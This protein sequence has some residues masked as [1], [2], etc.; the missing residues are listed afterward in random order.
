MIIINSRFLTQKTTGVQ[1]FAIEICK[2]LKK[3]NLD[4]EFVSPKNIVDKN[5]ANYLGVKKIGFLTGHLWE[6]ITLQIYVY[7]KNALL[8]S[9]CNTAPVFLKNQI[10]TIHDLSFRLFPEWNS[11]IFSFV[12]NKMIPVLA[13]KSRHILTVSNTSKN[14]LTDELNVSKDKITVVY[15]AVSS[16]FLE[17]ELP[18]KEEE[19]ISED[20]ILTVSSFH[21]RKN[22]KRLIDAFL[23]ISDQ[24]LKLYI[25]GNFDKNF[26]Y[27]ELKGHGSRIKILTNI[28]DHVLK[29]YY[30]K[31]KLFVYPSLYEGFGIPIIEAMSCGIPVCVSNINVFRE[32]CDCSATYFDP[33]NI[34]DIREKIVLSINKP[35]QLIDQSKNYS[36]SNSA[37]L[38]ESI[39]IEL[40]KT[41]KIK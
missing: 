24:E 15:N 10:V 1:R 35:K 12:Y 14:E 23:K 32:V 3:S 6:Q 11:K 28:N 34:E 18:E 29:D 16:V 39:I 41:K 17:N 21:P 40:E 5:T 4:I 37:S 8:I 26:A 7:R 9:L 30:K 38:I 19:R 13:K 27:E 2:E 36:W 22:L 31:A 20:Y 33:Y 25:V